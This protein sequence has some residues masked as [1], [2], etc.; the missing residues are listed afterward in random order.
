LSKTRFDSVVT[1]VR[2]SL[3]LAKALVRSLESALCGLPSLS[4][5]FFHARLCLSGQVSASLSDFELSQPKKQRG[6]CLTLTA[7]KPCLAAP[8]GA[9]AGHC[10]A[11][12]ATPR[13]TGPRKYYYG[14]LAT[15][16]QLTQG[17]R[18]ASLL[19]ALLQ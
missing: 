19:Y 13:L 16:F 3:Q 18:T 5:G 15:K 1:L 14:L 4:L 12:R 2:R 10:R 6:Q 7:V 8:Y 9:F 17:K 11:Y